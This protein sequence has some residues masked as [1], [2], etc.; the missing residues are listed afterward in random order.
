MGLVPDSSRLP[1]AERCFADALHAYERLRGLG[2]ETTGYLDALSDI[3]SSSQ[4]AIVH[5]R[6]HGDAYVLLAQAFYLWHLAIYPTSNDKLPIRLA[7]AT[8]QHW[9]DRPVGQSLWTQ[10]VEK[11]CRVYE[12]VARALADTLSDCADCAEREMRYLEAELLPLALTSSPRERV[13]A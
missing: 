6:R 13:P 8:I 12:L 10:N 1:E 4:D 7:A 5:D 2:I 3:L 9:C 11:G